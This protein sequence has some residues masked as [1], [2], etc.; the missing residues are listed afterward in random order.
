MS[1]LAPVPGQIS[2]VG[3]KLPKKMD[4]DAWVRL[5]EQLTR[6][7]EA[8][9]WAIADWLFYGEWE[10]GRRYE[11]AIELTG[12]SYQALNDLKYVA[13]RFDISR[14]REKLSISHH[15]EVAALPPPDADRLL[16]QASDEGWSRNRL[17]DEVA[18]RSRT[19]SATARTGTV[20]PPESEP[21]DAEIV[22]Q[23]HGDLREKVVANWLKSTFGGDRDWQQLARNV[24]E[25]AA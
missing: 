13:G 5:G 7:H 18:E 3:L 10:Y 23:A 15:R 11:E 20:T 21:D 2:P 14:R 19:R 17:R 12:L 1:A 4:Y 6:M 24:L 16:A 8:S 25:L 9:S 22:D